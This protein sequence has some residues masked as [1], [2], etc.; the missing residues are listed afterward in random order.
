M[1][2]GPV[3]FRS[4][5]GCLSHRCQTIPRLATKRSAPTPSLKERRRGA[6]NAHSLTIA[7]AVLRQKWS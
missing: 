1:H 3:F 4:L 2:M 6:S 7:T 5:V